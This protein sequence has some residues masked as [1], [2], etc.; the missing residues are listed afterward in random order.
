MTDIEEAATKAKIDFLDAWISQISHGIEILLDDE[1]GV[2]D[3]I[4][5]LES[6]RD[7]LNEYHSILER[8]LK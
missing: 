6:K 3:H 2:I 7:L 4:H 8:R 1:E 5:S